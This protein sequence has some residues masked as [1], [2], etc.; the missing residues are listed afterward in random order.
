M[1]ERKTF[2]VDCSFSS[3]PS[4]IERRVSKK[5]CWHTCITKELESRSFPTK[6]TRC[7]GATVQSNSHGQF[8]C[9]STKRGFQGL[10]YFANMNQTIFLK[11]NTRKWEFMDDL[12]LLDFH[13]A[14]TEEQRTLCESCHDEGV[15]SYRLGQ[16][17][18][19]HITVSNCFHFVHLS[20]LGQFI[21]G[22]INGFQ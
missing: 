9:I 2:T 12:I 22:S 11:Q 8:G 16:S 5:Y 13:K 21:K 19:G 6:D 10:G 15:S 7:D 14:N 18:H 3:A 17:R 1:S 4:S 20:F